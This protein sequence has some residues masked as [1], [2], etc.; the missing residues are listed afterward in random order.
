MYLVERVKIV[1]RFLLTIFRVY[2][3]L[4]ILAPFCAYS[5]SRPQIYYKSL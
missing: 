3:C 2:S 1:I 5:V 4:C